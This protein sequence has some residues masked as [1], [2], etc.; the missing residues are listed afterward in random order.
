M[1]APEVVPFADPAAAQAFAAARGGAVMALADI[2]DS[3]VT[4]PV[5]DAATGDDDYARRLKALAKDPEG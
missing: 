5:T 4:A 2:P 3:A 1:G